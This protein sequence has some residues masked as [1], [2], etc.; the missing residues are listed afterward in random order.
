MM[1]RMVV[2][3][4]NSTA[5]HT[6]VIRPPRRFG[7]YMS[8][9]YGTLC[10]FLIIF[11][12]V[13]IGHGA[14]VALIALL[15]ILGLVALSI[16]ATR[17][18]AFTDQDALV[19]RNW[20]TTRRF[21][22]D[23]IRGFRLG[24]SFLG[25]RPNAL[26]VLHTNGSSIAISASISPWYLIRKDQQT[27]WLADLLGWLSGSREGSVEGPSPQ[28]VWLRTR[29]TDGAKMTDRRER[30]LSM[31]RARLFELAP[32]RLIPHETWAVVFPHEVDVVLPLHGWAA[33]HVSFQLAVKDDLIVGDWQ[34]AHYAW[35]VESDGMFAIPFGDDD[36]AAITR[37]LDLTEKELRRPIHKRLWWPSPKHVDGERGWATKGSTSRG[38]PVGYF[39]PL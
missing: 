16:R 26:Q 36:D 38:K 10:V 17:L 1:G 34:D 5:S 22:R 23:V 6:I 32:P 3:V 13:G 37:A 21:Q 31:M 27:K 9:C 35:D 39:E 14:T 19:V 28:A 29:V 30:I 24:G 7:A 8:A 20:T 18:S 25:S 11:A 4:P 2:H 15:P 33:R 12:A